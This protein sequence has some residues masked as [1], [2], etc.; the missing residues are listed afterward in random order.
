MS[1]MPF[2]KELQAY[3]EWRAKLV[4]AMEQYQLWLENQ[5]AGAQQAKPTV[6]GLIR[7][8]RDDRIILAFA[9]EFSRGKTE[10]I[11]SIFFS[12]SGT[13]LLPST[14][15]RT[16]MC[17]TEIFYDS[18][19]GSYIRLLPIETRLGEMSLA[20]HKQLP[21]GW[22]QIDIDGSSPAQMQEAF[23][24]LVAVKK[25]SLDDALR[26]GLYHEGVHAK[27]T[28]RPAEIEIPCWRHALISF[29]HQLLKDGLVILDTPGLNA[30]GTEPELTINMLPNAQAVMFVLAADTGVTKSDLEMWQ[31]HI[32]GFGSKNNK[33]LAVVLNKI[34]TLWDDLQSNEGIE[35]SIDLQVKSTASILDVEQQFI[36]PVSAKQ[37]LL[38]KIKSDD[39][40]LEKSRIKGLESF[41]SKEILGEKKAI[42]SDAVSR[43]IGRLVEESLN[44]LDSQIDS[45]NNQI[46]DLQRI[47][48]VNGV[49]TDRLMEETREEQSRYLANVESFQ[50]SQRVVNIQAK[51][52]VSTLEPEIV[53]SL[54]SRTKKD[55]LKCMTT[56]G[57]K[58]VMKNILEELK[59][60]LENA[61]ESSEETHRLVNAI[62]TKFRDDDNSKKLTPP[63][64][65]I[66]QYKLEL[67][68]LFA[69]GEQFRSSA[70]STF[71]EQN[72]VIHKL[73]S[74]VIEKAREIFV[75]IHNDTKT[76][77]AIVL[78]PLTRQIKNHKKLI[79][80]RLKMLREFNVQTS[81]VGS[82]IAE[83]EG[84]L[85]PFHNQR[86]QLYEIINA[87]GLE[88]DREEPKAD[89]DQTEVLPMVAND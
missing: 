34:D 22:M 32:Q 72:I 37:A 55:M 50:A 12:E 6:A 86:E 45:I 3:G 82:H 31:R 2:Q 28:D 35:H 65:S 81:D 80:T 8:L 17:P 53:E 26:L 66:E 14:P 63:V 15:G 36:F 33:G 4:G 23:K 49:M 70:S 61:V 69:E 10:L 84:Q 25:A 58:N 30:L 5:D 19:G 62:Y 83:F 76:W 16:T 88:F 24:E 75:A 79:E 48:G 21:K 41:L 73:Y 7:T 40:L 71:M 44:S 38:A 51:T 67:E 54:V 9:A 47:E 78:N 18:T 11:N 20:E 59:D 1:N 56:L 46:K 52:M 13:R 27:Q 87:I 77:S 89:N 74:L 39:K 42:L 60:L 57:M 68:S 29:P 64:F 43:N 85:L